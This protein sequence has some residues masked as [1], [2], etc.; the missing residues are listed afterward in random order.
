[1]SKKQ[2]IIAIEAYGIRHEIDADSIVL[3]SDFNELFR[4]AGI[5]EEDYVI[6]EVH[7]DEQGMLDY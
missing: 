4:A 3:L 5:I 6:R 7:Q 2:N 1:M